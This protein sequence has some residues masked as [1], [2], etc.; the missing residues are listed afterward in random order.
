MASCPGRE[1]GLTRLKGDRPKEQGTM[2]EGL[3][4][5]FPGGFLSVTSQKAK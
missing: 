4:V 3:P 5:H 2:T 1:A